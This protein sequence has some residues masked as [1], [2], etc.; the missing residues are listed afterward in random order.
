MQLL[1]SIG[2]LFVLVGG[3]L[4]PIGAINLSEL[5][6]YFQYHQRQNETNLQKQHYEKCDI[7]K[8]PDSELQNHTFQL[9]KVKQD[10]FDRKDFQEVGYQRSFWIYDFTAS[11]FY[12]VNA[13]LL[14][15]GEYSLVFMETNCITELGELAAIG[16]TETIRDE[17]D[18]TI[19]PRITDLA[20]H[21]NGTLGDIDGDP[22]III[23]LSNC[24]NYYSERNE[25]PLEYSN[26][27]E[28][29]YIH[30]RIPVVNVV[31][32]EF[33]HLIW[34]NN[35]WDEPQFI[36]EALAQYAMYHAGYLEP[37]HNLAPQ[38]S[39]FLPH[40]E[41]S[42]LY[43]NMYNDGGV[44][45]VIDYGSSYLFAFYIA[46]QYGVEI[47]R[48]LITEP[49]DGPHGIEAVLQTAGYDITFNE[50]YLNWITALTIDELGFCNNLYGF[51]N[52]DARI[53]RY[54]PVNGLPLLNQTISLR[55]YGFHIHKLQSPLENF[56]V[57]IRKSS[58]QTIGVSIALHDAFG[59]HIYQNLH[60]EEGSII[61]DIFMGNR[62]DVAYI[63]TS[64]MSNRTPTTT[65]SH[66]LGLGPL[67]YIEISII[68]A[69]IILEVPWDLIIP[70]SAF[71]GIC[72]LSVIVITIRKRKR[73][74]KK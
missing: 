16:K 3:I 10:Q 64:F 35:E 49:A 5:E 44:S 30:Y 48:N 9:S 18:S 25:L 62:I 4:I 8:Q 13:T 53:T 22:R 1:G 68:T 59:W 72:L 2:L 27:C 54:Y 29:I 46:E 58:N 61:T 28:M 57:Q 40:P 70:L 67:T 39:A 6:S 21:P 45:A 12:E 69:P 32:H 26:Q 43:W 66:D 51:E 73:F 7:L 42:L 37:H 56:T 38:V 11:F 24:A 34:F 41:E 52:L 14:A 65:R 17:F 31:A 23:L 47:L 36:L 33:H 20:G 74:E 19:Y 71:C 50:L 55:Y 63:I 15:K 60:D